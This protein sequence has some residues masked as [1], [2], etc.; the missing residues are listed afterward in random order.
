MDFDNLV[1]FTTKNINQQI[2]FNMEN[3]FNL[4]EEFDDSQKKYTC[5]IMEDEF[6]IYVFSNEEIDPLKELGQI[7]FLVKKHSLPEFCVSRY[8]DDFKDNF[9]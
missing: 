8:E 3:Y 1:I 7:N 9:E 5:S 2:F 6:F 4:S